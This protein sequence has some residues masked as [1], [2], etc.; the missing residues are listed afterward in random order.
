MK[1]RKVAEEY[2]SKIEQEKLEKKLKEEYKPTKEEVLKTKL[3]TLS[4]DH[5]VFAYDLLVIGWGVAIVFSSMLYYSPKIRPL[6]ETITALLVIMVFPIIFSLIARNL[7]KS[8][9]GEFLQLRREI[10]ELLLNDKYV[11]RAALTKTRE[12]EITVESNWKFPAGVI[13]SNSGPVVATLDYKAPVEDQIKMLMEIANK[14]ES[15]FGKID[16]IEAQNG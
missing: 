9:K 14:A 2:V 3:D 15:T 12:M 10:V 1:A 8:E 4:S 16:K 7:F 6:W 11:V 13:K 5:P